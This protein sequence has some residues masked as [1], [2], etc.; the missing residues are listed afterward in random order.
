MVIKLPLNSEM[1]V[2]A[3]AIPETM[4][5]SLVKVCPVVIKLEL[6]VFMLVVRV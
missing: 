3:S 2:W 1:S 6:F 4:A 5:I